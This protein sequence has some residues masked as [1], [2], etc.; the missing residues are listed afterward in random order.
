MSTIEHAMRLF[1]LVMEKNGGFPKKEEVKKIVITCVFISSKY[2]EIY[3]PTSHDYE[4][5]SN[6]IIKTSELLEK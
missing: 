5:V 1:D 4:Y 2:V 6:Y 3:P